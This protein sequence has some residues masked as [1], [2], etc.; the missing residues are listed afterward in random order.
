MFFFCHF[1][2]LDDGLSANYNNIKFSLAEYYV[3][4]AQTLEFTCTYCTYNLHI[5]RHHC[6]HCIKIITAKNYD[7]IHIYFL[8]N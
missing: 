3:H 7:L 4:I 2:L 5:V 1:F 8:M 6:L